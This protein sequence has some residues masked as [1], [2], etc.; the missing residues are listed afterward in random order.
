MA[1]LAK[2]DDVG[3]DLLI[4][5]LDADERVLRARGLTGG[6]DER[7]AE[8]L[9]AV[10]HRDERRRIAESVDDAFYRGEQLGEIPDDDDD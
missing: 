4:A 7:H 6:A 3:L 8:L 9:Q 2:L 5:R 1:D 10:E